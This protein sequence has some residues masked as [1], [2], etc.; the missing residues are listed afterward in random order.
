MATKIV[1]WARRSTP[2]CC[3]C[4]KRVPLNS[5]HNVR[6]VITGSVVAR[7]C[8]ASCVRERA[9]QN[10]TLDMVGEP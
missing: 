5:A 8:S 1:R 10:D 9:R 2:R 4:G 7:F 3:V 6:S